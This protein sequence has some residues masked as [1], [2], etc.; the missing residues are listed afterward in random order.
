MVPSTQ[1]PLKRWTGLTLIWFHWSPSGLQGGSSWPKV[2]ITYIRPPQTG[3]SFLLRHCY[4]HPLISTRNLAKMVESEVTKGSSY[5]VQ[6]ER[7]WF[8]LLLFGKCTLEK[9]LYAQFISFPVAEI[10]CH[11][12]MKSSVASLLLVFPSEHCSE[13]SRVWVHSTGSLEVGWAT[14]ASRGAARGPCGIFIREMESI[15]AMNRALKKKKKKDE[16]MYAFQL[17]V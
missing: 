7:C 16:S 10:P 15:F 8:S 9:C 14:A 5:K 17:P 11:N 3:C 2:H 6:R 4:C 12:W 1:L 13:G